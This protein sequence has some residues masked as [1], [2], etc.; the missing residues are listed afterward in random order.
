[1]LTT[2][3]IGVIEVLSMLDAVGEIDD[4]DI[5]DP[6]HGPSDSVWDPYRTMYP[7]AFAAPGGWRLHVRSTLL[8]AGGRTVLVDTGVGDAGSPAMRWF[9]TPGRLRESLAACGTSPGEVDVVVLTHA[10]DDHIGGTVTADGEPTFPN[11]RY[12]INRIELEWQEACAKDF[13]EDR[14]IWNRLL[15]PLISLGMLQPVDGDYEV[16]P[17]IV[18]RHLP[19]HTPGHQVVQVRDGA[20]SLVIS[21]DS[22]NHPAQLHEPELGTG[23]DEDVETAIQSRRMLIGELLDSDC[24]MA[25]AHFAEPFGRVVSDGPSGRVAWIPLAGPGR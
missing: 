4:P 23:P 21:G 2:M 5:L 19:G 11:A 6:H 7:A 20:D 8:R 14:V 24:M 9:P 17:G 13:A 16:M 3:S 25:P 1:M 22:I 12:V 10:H 15:A 18:T